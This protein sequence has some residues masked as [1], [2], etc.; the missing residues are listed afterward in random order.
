MTE[1]KNKLKVIVCRGLA[2]S[3]KTTYAIQWVDEDPANRVLVE[4]DRI[5]SQ[6]DLFSGNIYNYKR[7]DEAIVLRERDRL[8]HA[9]LASGKSVVSSDTNLKQRHITQIAN[10]ARQHGAEVE[11]KS[12]LDVPMKELLYRDSRRL[13]SVGEQSIRRAFHEQVKKM[14]TFLR[15]D[16][17]LPFVVI[18]DLD[19]TLTKGPKNR[20][21]HEWD[22]VGNDELNLG[23]AHVLD[24]IRVIGYAKIFIVTSR[25]SV[26]RQQTAQ[27]LERNDVEYD[28]LY[29]RASGDNRSDELVKAEMIEKYIRDKYNVLIWFD[30]RPRVATMLRDVYGI[31]VAQLG[32]TRYNF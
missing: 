18:T 32:D 22:K 31:N 28:R 24:G 20:S 27:W 17:N 25:D 16:Q 19:G 1:N 6:A 7:G 14:P 30:D 13:N 15:Y 10:I 11:I 12:F 5:R 4:K 9:A 21:P 26:C 2:A 3:G 29:M 23:V 8:I